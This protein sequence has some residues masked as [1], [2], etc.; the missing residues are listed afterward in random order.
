MEEYTRLCRCEDNVKI[1]LKEI[2]VDVMSKLRIEIIGE[3]LAL[4]LQI[5]QATESTFSLV[6]SH[7]IVTV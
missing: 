3:P 6:F 4:N 1:H 2:G 7:V 5:T